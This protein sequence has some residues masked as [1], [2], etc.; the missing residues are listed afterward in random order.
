MS[1]NNVV[2][3][4]VVELSLENESFESNSRQSLSTLDKLKQA[5]KFENASKGFDSIND[6]IKNVN[7]GT[8]TAGVN[9]LKGSLIALKDIAVFSMIADE[10]IK[11]KNAVEGF[12]KSVTLDQV[13]A[14]WEKYAQKTEAVQTIMAATAKDW[15][16]QGKQMEYVNAQLE[17]L[18]WFTDETS[19]NFTDMVG[20]IGKFT[21]NNVKLDDAVTA[22]E[23]IS[24]WAG[25][26][27]AKTQEASHAM[28]NLSQAI[29]TGAV[30]LMDWKSIE[31]ANMATAQ[32]KQTAIETAAE[33][34]TLTKVSDGLYKTLEG[35]EVSVT[36]FNSELKDGWFSS[37]VLLQTLDKY[38]AFTTRL[39]EIMED[40]GDSVVTS[41]V[42]GYIEEFKNG[43]VNLSEAARE[44][45]LS[46]PETK[47]ILEELGAE[48]YDLGF[49]AFQASQQAVT[50][51]QAIE[52]VKDAVSTGWTK[53][54][55]LVFGDFLEAKELWT[56]LAE[57]LWDVFA[58]GISET[59]SKLKEA[60]GKSDSI[61]SGDWDKLKEAG[62]AN[63]EFIE[64]VRRNARQH[65]VYVEMMADNETW[66]QTVLERGLLTIDDIDAA[67]EST[68]GKGTTEVDQNILSMVNSAKESDE[69]FQDLLA[70]IEKFDKADVAKIIFGNGEVENA[71]LEQAL[72]QMI[73][74][75]GL[76]QDDGEAL[77]AV[78]TSLGYF[79]GEMEDAY[80]G[81]TDAQLKQLG[82]TKEEIE[83]IRKAEDAA[84]NYNEAKKA[85]DEEHKTGKQLWTDTLYNGLETLTS[86]M[87]VAGEMWAEVFPSSTSDDIY[88]F[89]VA[90]ND[91]SESALNFV[92]NNETLKTVLKGFFSVLH[93]G[94]EIVLGIGSTIKGVATGVLDG[95]GID[96]GDIAGKVGTA[97]IKFNEWASSIN[98]FGR[99][100]SIIGGTAKTV[101][102]F[103]R[104]LFDQF[105]QIPFVS[106]NITRFK[107]AFKQVFEGL[108][109]YIDGGLTAISDFIKRIEDMGG[110]N[111]DNFGA[112]FKDFKENVL[113]Y[114]LNFPGFKAVKNA[115]KRMLGD[116]KSG[117]KGGV[118]IAG[119]Y[120]TNLRAK[121]EGTFAG[122]V[123][124]F[125]VD[126]V[127]QVKDTIA[128][129]MENG[130]DMGQIFGKIGDFI[131]GFFDFLSNIPFAKIG[132]IAAIAAPILVLVKIVQK[133][134][135][136]FGFIGT[137]KD[138]FSSIGDAFSN[139]TE[140]GIQ[141]LLFGKGRSNKIA[142]MAALFK[143]FAIAIGVL[144]AGLYVLSTIDTAKL[145][146]S[147]GALAALAVILG[148]ISIAMAKFGKGMGVG[149]G[150]G[151]I[152]V[153]A[154][155][156]IMAG[157][158]KQLSE[159]D[160]SQ[161]L[162]GTIAVAALGAILTAIGVLM[163]NFGSGFGLG[164]GLG[165]ILV[166]AAIS[167]LAGI[168]KQLSAFSDEELARG[169]TAV[170]ALGAILTAI[171]VI[172]GQ[173][174]G[175]FGVGQGLGL[176]LASAA[177]TILAG[178][179]KQLSAFSDE[180]LKR[181]LITIAI[182]GAVLAAVAAVVGNFGG[183]FGV[184]KG[185]GLVLASAAIAILGNV[186]AQLSTL[187]ASGLENAEKAIAIMGACLAA[188][189]AIVG[190]FGGDFSI[191]D[192]F[193]LLLEAGAIYAVSQAAIQLSAIDGSG[194]ENA[195]QAIA[196][197]SGC[198]TAMTAIIGNFGGDFGILDAFGTLLEAGA[199]YAVSQAAIQLSAIDGSG[200]ENAEQAI[201]L[202]SGC[203]TA[204]T[205]IIGNF[206]GD[207]SLFD[208][209]GTLVEAGAIVFVAQAAAQLSVIDGSGLEN[210]EQAIAVI[211]G[212]LAAMTAIIGN[213]GGD[214]SILD[215]FGTL[216]EAGAIYAVAKAGALLSTLDSDGL[217]QAEEA[218]VI[219]AGCLAVM[220]AIIGNFGGDF[221]ILD[222]FGTLV[223]AGAIYAMTQAAAQLSELDPSGLTQAEQAI[224]IFT[225]CLSAL[226]FLGMFTNVAGTLSAIE[227]IG[228]IVGSFAGAALALE[229]INELIPGFRTFLNDGLGILVD[230]GKGIGDFIG[231]IIGGALNSIEL[232]SLEDVSSSLVT[233]VTNLQ[234]LNGLDEI[235]FGVL[236]SALGAITDIGFTELL[237]ALPNVATQAATGKTSMEQFVKDVEGL[238]EALQT[239][240][241]K[242]ESLGE[243]F[244]IDT[245]NISALILAVS[246]V[247]F[248]GLFGALGDILIQFTSDDNY[249]TTTQEF[250]EK[251]G[252][253]GTA[254]Q[255]WK[256]S[257]EGLGEDYQVD[258]S[259]ITKLVTALE[260]VPKSGLF[261]AIAGFFTGAPDMETFK[262][263][264][265]DLGGALTSFSDSLG[266]DMDTEKV[267]ASADVI[268]S[269]AQVG[270]A[271]KKVDF[272]GQGFLGLSE[273]DFEQ[274]GKSINAFAPY[275]KQF[276]EYDFGDLDKLTI[277][278]TVSEQLATVGSTFA[279]IDLSSGDIAK[280]SV[281]AEFGDNIKS[282]VESLKSAD[283][284]NTKGV[285]GV[286]DAVEKITNVPV[287]DANKKLQ[288]MND[289]VSNNA[290][291]DIT[292]NMTEGIDASAIV[293][294]A[295]DAINAAMSSLDTSAFSTI[296]EGIVSAIV[297]GL[298]DGG[299]VTTAVKTMVNNAKDAISASPF[300]E[301]GRMVA[302]GFS[303]GISLNA[304]VAVESA[305]AMA[306]AAVNVIKSTIQQGSPSKV[307]RESGMW[308]ALGFSKGI[309]EYSDNVALSSER[310]GQN[311]INS[312]KGAV[313][314]ISA[315]LTEDIAGDPVIRPVLDLTDI[316]NGAGQLSN[317]LNMSVPIPVTGQMNAIN[318]NVNGYVRTT[319]DDI[320]AALSD[321][322]GALGGSGGNTYVIDGI[323]YD[324]G[325][326]I[327]DAVRSLV[328]A[329]NVGRR[330]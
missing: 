71:E 29:A 5:L 218:I 326:N 122:K 255:T 135:G 126:T 191:F 208:A 265:G 175:K 249:Q 121:L 157:I 231:G 112:V 152:L 292:N 22:M 314:G 194:L 142:D 182:L 38:G 66:L 215:S 309:T 125:V 99:V 318:E 138:T 67:F 193:G 115:F 156:A 230:I 310:M 293:G 290:G 6:S 136:L 283:G 170:A 300:T 323:T 209:F 123:L 102:G 104:N 198:L 267:A 250:V 186:A 163:A 272:G 43:T 84:K 55:E 76:A 44:L 284:F 263:N 192:G 321:L 120:I 31:N 88:N 92:Q 127:T 74:S 78:L 72:D 245:S 63:P 316:Q 139:F 212:C 51:E 86:L 190:N 237:G 260:E 82:L 98:L 93:T 134:K 278:G 227:S 106:K 285:E 1:A 324:D 258:T 27:G 280:D 319:N 47:K 295:Q 119:D 25:I 167:I 277:L 16:D 32:F 224:G 7:V 155:I 90:I 96:L 130:L 40:L 315:M 176:I 133:V 261:S 173:A 23:G 164:N 312:L 154:A 266:N 220:S 244:T 151:L 177:I 305:R 81:M 117:L 221:S 33:L 54:F 273:N 233:F 26:S 211:A 276:G 229:G 14:G 79:G 12:V 19:Y 299:S 201:A 114:F 89:I 118:E 291:S 223:E 313:N 28:Y 80:S 327:T 100:A 222:A 111:L 304:R 197:I 162:R 216:V 153:S 251:V 325:S 269:L 219:F 225:A 109:D 172:M 52:S 196:L 184:G 320:V 62:I 180:E 45:G 275:L 256:E 50:F 21:S 108:P 77:V 253:L 286:V 53:T 178:V 73:A 3:S 75:L 61:T 128:H 183:D 235:D 248:E 131:G 116:V 147:V 94:L 59:N 34:G 41:D 165:F 85:I 217:S 181:S 328:R 168:V 308:F 166:S 301:S 169:T 199:I 30:K 83:E 149:K 37:E 210:A 247:D 159:L 226:S 243:G 296:G 39:S 306:Q 69:G 56:T 68:F 46:V 214:F 171:G 206:G 148:G 91:L 105:V 97:A 18:N 257:T 57:D 95:L 13:S 302:S 330:V 204:M 240:K 270:Q 35:H 311:A 274:F 254:L 281:V 262:T 187:D 200:L 185:V 239:W 188:M 298:G 70:T 36:N 107:Y 143:N 264:M 150:V 294:A 158:V 113:G 241:E 49:K 268:S 103:V 236:T 137:I 252:D 317:M 202:I 58:S 64:A 140:N 271:L 11:A 297:T 322:K 101:A 232:P 228:I 4:K 238:G 141:G 160:N 329:A 307:T 161:I 303:V 2:D 189:A 203:L 20:N 24:V 287:G 110:L 259:G 10:A 205:A 65:G 282:L 246:A 174:G 48:T 9:T 124:G 146:T 17:R 144:V 234:G 213:F 145:F 87:E 8:L 207:F 179:V 195:E 129:V 15:E 288:Q 42:V 60:F 242:T 289:T 132:K 279:T